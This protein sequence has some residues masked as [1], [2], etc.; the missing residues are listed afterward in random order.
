MRYNFKDILNQEIYNN[1]R[2]MVITGKYQ[3]FNNLVADTLKDISIDKNIPNSDY[4]G[5]ADEFGI[6]EEEATASTSVD[7]D[8][9]FEVVNVSNINGKW[10]CRVGLDS[11]NKKQK[12]QINSYIKQPSK[13]GILVL[14]STDFKDYKDFLKNKS[15]LFGQYA[16]LM[17][18]SFPNRTILKSIVAMMFED[19]NIE[20][21]N[22][23]IEYFIMRLN[24]EYDKY[25]EVIDSIVE[26]HK[27]N[28][29]NFSDMKSYLKGIEYFDID[30]FME[31]LVKPLASGKTGNKKIIRML[32]SLRDKYSAEDLVNQI[33]SRITELIEYRIMINK[34]Y[35]TINIRYIFNDVLKLLG[36]DNKY[37]KVNEWVFRKKADL[38]S[39]TSLED[40]VYMN[41]MLNKAAT[42]GYPE[43]TERKFA[44]ERALY[45][46]ITRSVLSAD[47]INNI[48]GID[49]VLG[50]T[51]LT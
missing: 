22:Q 42:T 31:E 19:K 17:Q 20:V 21:D 29:L 41:I 51:M 44:C 23:A 26:K 25:E 28:Q 3:L 32:S 11:L 18:L 36:P 30:D 10:F 50:K 16:H 9:F 46:I 39:M 13:N 4:L 47:R 35:I 8:T 45:D 38:A 49:N 33:Q 1:T 2:V 43:S 5:L 24:T 27:D 6:S 15:L 48:I 37:S 14:M 12:D 7:I 40:W 34:G